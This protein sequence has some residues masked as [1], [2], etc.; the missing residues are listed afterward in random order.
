MAL[1]VAYFGTYDPAY[2][3]NRVLVSGLRAAGAEVL[4]YCAPLDASLTAAEMTTAAGAGKLAFEL[5]RAHLALLSRHR[6]G[7]GFDIVVVGYP[8]HLLVPLA[9][10]VARYR[11]ATLVF[12]PLVSLF[13]TFAGDRELLA[14][15]SVAGHL[16]GLI[17][18]VSFALPDLVLADTGRHA[19]YYADVLRVPRARLAVVPVGAVP[20][21]GA[22]GAARE[23][24]AGEAVRVVQYGRWSPLHGLPTVLDA[25]ELLRDEPFVFELIGDGQLAGWLADEVRR[26]ALS[27]VEL[28]DALP[29][30][31]LRARVLAA[32]VC[33][34]VFGTSDKAGRVVPNKVYD[35]LAA[36]RPLVTAGSPAARELLDDG[37]D[38]LLVPAGD[39]AALAAALRR[40][41]EAGERAR[42]GAAALALYR[43]RC[44]PEA[45]AAALL[46]ALE[47][48]S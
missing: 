26:R 1:R 47:A 24:E 40:L 25:A 42:L 2:P 15:D 9:W 14:G 38:A 22:S 17:D 6:R 46:A 35:A 20:L 11:R 44:T 36:G 23:L 10:A 31:R 29:G 27:A 45:V 37:R 8:G 21:A 30:W 13:D 28:V 34:G 48:R 39:A 43:R 3:R 18:R 19:D 32:D 41:G 7:V 12:D 33:L 4:E 5:A 16:A